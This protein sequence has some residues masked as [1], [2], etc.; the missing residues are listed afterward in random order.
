[1][2]VRLPMLRNCA[3]LMFVWSH[4]SDTA[5]STVINNWLKQFLERHLQ[6]SIQKQKCL[7]LQQ[8]IL[9]NVKDIQQWFERFHK[10]YGKH[11]IQ[12]KDCWNMDES[13]FRIGVRKNQWIITRDVSQQPY[14]ASSNNCELVT[15]V[16]AVSGGGQVLLPMVI[17]PGHFIIQWWV[18]WTE[19]ENNCLLALPELGYSN[20]K[21]SLE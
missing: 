13:G 8:K 3:N 18:T 2:A 5:L 6:Y 20:N 4:Q 11:G 21:L 17:L 16:K 10:E 14:L 1:M 19:L 9:H 12:S 7:D 15:V